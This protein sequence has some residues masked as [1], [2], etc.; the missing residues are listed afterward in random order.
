MAITVP[1]LKKCQNIVF[2]VLLAKRSNKKWYR[3]EKNGLVLSAEN[4]PTWVGEIQTFGELTC[5]DP[6]NTTNAA[7]NMYLLTKYMSTLG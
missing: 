1:N 6:E 3:N 2:C 5:I 4:S 7:K